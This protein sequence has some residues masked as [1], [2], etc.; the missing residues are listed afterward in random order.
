MLGLFVCVCVFFSIHG[1]SVLSSFFPMLTS[2]S[3]REG[4]LVQSEPAAHPGGAAA[5]Q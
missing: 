4:G 1:L 2:G 5:G 3:G